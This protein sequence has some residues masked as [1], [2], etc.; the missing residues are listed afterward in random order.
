M[1]YDMYI[2]IKYKDKKINIYNIYLY[3]ILNNVK[4][5]NQIDF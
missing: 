4:K 2:F 3:I 1:I 5:L